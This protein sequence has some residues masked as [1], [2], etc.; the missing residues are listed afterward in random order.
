MGRTRRL[1]RGLIAGLA[2]LGTG[3]LGLMVVRIG[4]LPP[5]DQ[6]GA[7]K[8]WSFALTA[9]GSVITLLTFA[10]NLLREARAQPESK[11]ETLRLLAEASRKQWK[12]AA[13]ERRLQNPA[14][15]PVRWRLS[16]A[17][18]AGPPSASEYRRFDPLPGLTEIPRNRLRNGD[19]KALHQV[20]GGLPSGRLLLIGPPGSGKSS[21]AILLLLD[22]LRF[23]EQVS[24]ENQARI[25]V[26]VLFTLHGW[27]PN[28]G[29][30]FT[31]WMAGKL[32]ETYSMFRGRAGR[33]RA[34]DLLE[35]GHLAVFLDGLDEIPES[36]R[37][38]V[39]Q[40]LADAP[41]R[42]VV[43]TRVDAVEHAAS[44][45]PLAGAVALELQPVN[46][47]DA[48]AHLLQALVHPAPAP[49]QEISDDLTS[50][51]RR[52]YASALSQALTTPMTLSLLRD[53]Y[54]PTDDV[55]D[56]LNATRFPHA[57]AIEDHLL[58]SATIAAYTP[59]PG[60]PRPPY[61]VETARRTLRHLALQLKGAVDPSP[62][63]RDLSWW[64]SPT[65]TKPYSRIIRA[66][67]GTW[68]VHVP[69]AMVVLLLTF[70]L[71]GHHAFG[72]SDRSSG[73]VVYLLLRAAILFG[74]T[75]ALIAGLIIGFRR[76]LTNIPRQKRLGYRLTRQEAKFGL[77]VGVAAGL[78]LGIVLGLAYG[79]VG[80][81]VGGLASGIGGIAAALAAG[82]TSHTETSGSAFDPLDVW[83]HD[84]NAGFI[85]VLMIVLVVGLVGGIAT[86]LG[87]A[88]GRGG[89]AGG[90]MDGIAGGIGDGVLGGLGL[91]LICVAAGGP[92]SAFMETFFFCVQLRIQHKLPLRLVAFL[93]DARKRNLLRTV[94]PV[95]QFRHAKLQDRLAETAQ[96]SS[97]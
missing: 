12:A 4:H 1:Q 55:N 86:G 24:Q 69:V 23:R 53:S 28:D 91:G 77:L 63:T 16:S 54:G 35:N 70:T 84:R 72:M 62:E 92:G 19:Q 29:T 6:S 50:T 46:P 14:P 26:P 56:L 93:E 34:K 40:A 88:S 37:P 95:Y 43:L 66:V 32:S 30:S 73:N 22:A 44:T 20:Y 42:L 89:P 79:P 83:R 27:Q 85:F 81:L 36:L 47:S 52:G 65:W 61:T 11:D 41:V 5:G 31:D 18:V 15:L 80:W 71:M 58:D 21:A 3:G 94:G 8:F 82:L 10:T 96:V 64:H 67:L 74:S 90:V 33:K 87:N 25:P 2:I 68:L 49:W 76:A 7:I 75:A 59:R 48:A 17:P 60:H 57:T 9:V 13:D 97:G 39:L 51:H 38:V 45:G 78:T